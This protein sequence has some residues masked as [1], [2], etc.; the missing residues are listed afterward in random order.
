MDVRSRGTIKIKSREERSA[1]IFNA[2]NF[3]ESYTYKNVPL[4]YLKLDCDYRSYNI[5]FTT[6]DIMMEDD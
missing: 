6:L 4:T 1:G 2:N 3:W 5:S